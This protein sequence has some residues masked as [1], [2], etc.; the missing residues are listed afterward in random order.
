MLRLVA[1]LIVIS[2]VACGSR[3]E[4]SVPTT[5][6][7]TLTDDAIALL[8]T[9]AGDRKLEDLNILVAVNFDEDDPYRRGNYYRFF[10]DLADMG[11]PTAVAYTWKGLHFLVDRKSAPFLPGT[12]VST[13]KASDG[14]DGFVFTS[15][16]L[17]SLR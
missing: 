4:P 9:F 16:L 11:N 15:P 3:D 13:S 8:R 17:P 6:I 2:L 12:V 5:P 1:A 7:V 10:I 14:S